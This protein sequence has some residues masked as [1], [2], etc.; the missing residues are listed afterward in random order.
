[1]TYERYT[2]A[3]IA[4]VLRQAEAVLVERLPIAPV[5]SDRHSIT[6]AGGDGTATI[7]AHRH[8]LETLVNAVTDQ[9]RTSR[10]DTEVRY[11]MASLPYQPGDPKGAAEGLPGGLSGMRQR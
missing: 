5:N 10:L 9:L 1:M 6:L 3:S 4:D 7:Q 2:A 8:G 11:F